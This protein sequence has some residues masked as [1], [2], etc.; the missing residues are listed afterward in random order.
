MMLKEPKKTMEIRNPQINELV[1]NKYP[2]DISYLIERSDKHRYRFFTD[3]LGNYVVLEEEE[4]VLSVIFFHGSLSHNNAF[5]ERNGGVFFVTKNMPE[6]KQLL[7]MNL[8]F[9][10]K[11]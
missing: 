9:Y 7:N 6:F 4:D 10:S 3:D 2:L 8:V 11:V 5:E 1:K